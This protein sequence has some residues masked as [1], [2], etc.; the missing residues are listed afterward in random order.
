M[1]PVIIAG[2]GPTGLG[3]AVALARHRVPSLVL[4]GQSGA[5]PRRWARSCVLHPDLAHWARL[6]GVAPEATGW[7]AWR[8][9]QRG[10]LLRRLEFP[11][12][13]DSPVHLP[14]HTL[15][16]ALRTVAEG[17]PLVRLVPGHR[18]TA[19]E[20]RDGDVVARAAEVEPDGWQA[21]ERERRW[22]GSFLVGCDGAR[23][24]V[25]KLLGVPFPGRTG[26][27]R[28]AVAALAVE[29]P[30]PAG[31][32]G[33]HRGLRHGDVTVR[34]L[35]G[36][37]WR[38]DWPLPPEEG[39]VT[40][41]TMLARVH[42]T[43]AAW[44]G[45]EV[46][47]YQLLDTGVHVCHQRLARRWRERRV[48]LA[49]DAAH[50]L[51]ALG[52]QQVAEGLRDADN[53]AWKLAVACHEGDAEPLLDSYEAERR[54]AVGERLRAVDQ[55]LPLVRG[56][57]GLVARLAGRGH[58]R[59]ALL[60]DGHVGRGALGAPARY[61]ASPVAPR[62]RR[63]VATDTPP[64]SPVVDVPVT[65]LDGTRGRL[66]ERLG[67]PLLLV[68]T[69]PGSRVWD[70]RLWLSAG[71]MPELVAA[72]RDLPMPAELL[73][74]DEYPGVVAHTLLLVRPSLFV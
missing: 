54:G 56:R 69:A 31:E 15:E 28:Y 5:S 21:A 52:T 74:T 30:W 20:Q 61:P 11:E 46:P 49:G 58:T 39:L 40:P 44:H 13:P 66:R 29:M 43:L 3:L 47:D 53:L 7:T 63:A 38:L 72:V 62:P 18:L 4:D 70:A 32:G 26:V 34:P 60:D 10:R 33:V 55:A 45:G 8:S 23:S 36:G 37:R 9:T 14:Q 24:T 59:L 17:E 51:G 71:L 48:F 16:Q 65:A 73:V 27:E 50:L 25:R 2:A 6:P 42:D 22:R 67:G 35:A 41:E 19:V 57:R 68:L 1:L 12:P 64:G